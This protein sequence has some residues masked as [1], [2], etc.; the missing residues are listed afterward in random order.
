[1][2]SVSNTSS[3]RFQLLDR[4]IAAIAVWSDKISAFICAILIATTA[5]A[6]AVYQFGIVVPWLDDVLRLLLIWLVYLGAVS[7]CIHNDHI[8]MDALYLLFPEPVRK[9]IDVMVA[10]MAIVLCGFIT[11]I[12]ADSMLRE[13]EY[14]QLLPSGYL[15]AW[16][17]SLA[18]PV[19]FGLMAVAYLSYL[20]AVIRGRQLR[21]QSEAERLAEEI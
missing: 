18:I 19:G 8:S 3:G 17:Q 5:I 2:M 12:G 16:P 20:L 21:P 7:L 6:M 13:I 11:K 10:L 14:G 9:A 4:L 1:M 15:P